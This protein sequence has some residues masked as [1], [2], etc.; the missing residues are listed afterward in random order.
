[1]TPRR[2]FA[3]EGVSAIWVRELRG[4][5]RGKRAFVFLTFYLAVLAGLLWIALSAVTNR[6]LGALESVS[7]GRG[8]FGAIVIVETLVVLILGPAYTGAAISQEREKG[9]FDLLVVTPISSMAIVV[10][11]LISA[12]AFLILIVG[13]SIPLASLAFL[14]G[15]VGVEDLLTAYLVIISVGV[16]AA[17]IGIAS[18]AIFRRSQPATVAA[19]V[20]VAMVAGASTIAWISLQSQAIQDNTPQPPQALLYPNPFV[21]QADVLC[22]AVG[23][24]CFLQ[25]VERRVIGN[26]VPQAIGPGGVV[27]QQQPEPANQA[28]SV[29][30]KSVAIWLIVA[31][32]GVLAAADSVSPTRRLAHRPVRRRASPDAS[33]P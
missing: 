24:G 18:S 6:P 28:G 3:L 12:M 15:G 19:F 20:A 27:V 17:A 2:P 21:A 26:A 25:P 7:V 13:A 22:A 32:I 14:F 29:W 33:T 16:G 5:M 30:P 1:L 31:V 23:G 4:R 8:I 11:K 9:T 10:G